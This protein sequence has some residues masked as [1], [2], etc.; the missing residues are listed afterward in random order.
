[1]LHKV[2]LLKRL[3]SAKARLA[4]GLIPSQEWPLAVK[5]DRGTEFFRVFQE[6]FHDLL[7]VPVEFIQRRTLAVRTREARNVADVEARV[8][9]V[10]DDGRV[11][12]HFH[13]V[14]AKL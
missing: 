5:A 9:A 4:S 12:L 11:R 10:L 8:R 3:N 2:P 13:I 7:E 6:H 14:P 1:M